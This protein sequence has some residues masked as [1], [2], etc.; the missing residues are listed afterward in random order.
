MSDI[1]QVERGTGGTHIR[2]I[3]AQIRAAIEGTGY[4][5]LFKTQDEFDLAYRT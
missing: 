3:K 2:D 1:L 5:A 4:A